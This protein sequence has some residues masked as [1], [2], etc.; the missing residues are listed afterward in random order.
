MADEHQERG[1]EYAAR[2]IW[3]DA[4]KEWEKALEFSPDYA[5]VYNNIGLAHI[6]LEDHDK[7][8][9]ALKS[10]LKYFP[11]WAMAQGNLGLAQLRGGHF[12]EAIAQ[13]R[14]ALGKNAKQAFIWSALG[15]AYEGAG[16]IDEA[17]DAYRNAANNLSKYGFA[18]Y[19]LGMLLA[20]KTE[21]DEADRHL[22]EALADDPSLADAAAV[23]GAIA[24][25]RGSLGIARSYFEQSTN[26]RPD[27]VPA[28]AARGLANL[29][30][31]E[32]GMQ[33]VQRELDAQYPDV[34]TVAECMFN[35]GLAYL[36]AGDLGQARNAFQTAVESDVNWADPLVWLG[37]VE[38]LN[39]DLPAARRQWEAGLKLSPQDGLVAEAIGM[40]C[41]VQGLTKEAE[42]YFEQARR[43]GRQIMPPPTPKPSQSNIQ[44]AARPSGSGIQPA[45]GSGVGSGI[46][47][48]RPSGSGL[49]PAKPAGSGMH[50]KPGAKPA[51]KLPLPKPK[52]R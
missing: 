13:F 11:G 23:L 37:L 10:A 22:R 31:F 26:A 18:Q 25:R 48:A 35:A 28:A 16:K 46:G 4:I 7:A 21:L 5:E 47:Q 8:I 33:K 19:R 43:A 3:D 12:E 42:R 9:S 24:A 40:V 30:F 27:A 39:K 44:P 52:R 17:I 38:S 2:G 34:P 50:A 29:D 49:Q 41:Q 1:L 20:R 45:S 14:N 32:Q 51:A 6:Y 15:E 36:K